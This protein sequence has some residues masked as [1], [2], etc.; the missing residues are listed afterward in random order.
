MVINVEQKILKRLKPIIENSDFKE[1]PNCFLYPK[2]ITKSSILFIGINPSSSVDQVPLDSYELSQTGNDH[3][4][5]RL[6]EKISNE[7]QTPWT[8]LDLLY[9]RAT[10]QN[11]VHEILQKENGVQYIWEQLQITKDLIKDSQPKVMIV[12]DSL[13]RTFLGFDKNGEYN[14]WLDFEFHFDNEIG[15]YRWD[16]I[17]VFFT[18]ML[19]GQR[20]MD[21]G[22]YDRLK[23]QIRRALLI[24]A[25]QDLVKIKAN[26]SKSV[27]EGHYEMV[28]KLRDHEK[29]AVERIAQLEFSPEA[30]TSK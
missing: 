29:L 19:T 27:T 25:K 22:S 14:K 15:T 2:T 13:A 26:K 30:L 5:F 18:S 23:W 17:P 20:A 12:C 21:N 3:G 24:T 8:H 16:N 9:F 11:T 10:K 6:L 4:Y 7:C 28:A 1:F